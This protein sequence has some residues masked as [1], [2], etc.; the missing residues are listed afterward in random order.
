MFKSI[1]SKRPRAPL[2]QM[3]R[4]TREESKVR[5]GFSGVVWVGL[6]VVFVLLTVFILLLIDGR[7]VV[8]A[9]PARQRTWTAAM[10][11]QDWAAVRRLA[12]AE[13]DKNPRDPEAQ[14]ALGVALMETGNIE[15]A[16]AYLIT[17]GS[18]A[19]S[20]PEYTVALADLYTLRGATEQAAGKLRDA[21]ELDPSRVDLHWRLA[22]AAYALGQ[23]DESLQELQLI[24]RQ[25]PDNWDAYRLTADVAIG[26]AQS[27]PPEEAAA[28]Y[29]D[30]IGY[31]KLYTAMVPDARAL[32][33]MARVY[34]S[35]TPPDTAAARRAAE[36]ALA[37]NPTD[38]QAHLALARNDLIRLAPPNRPTP[39]EVKRGIER[40]SGHYTLA[41]SCF[42]P[43]RDASLMGRILNSRKNLAEAEV[44]YRV[45]ACVDTS[46]KDYAYELGMNL[47]TQQ[48]FEDARDS[49]E[50]VLRLDPQNL[51]A[52]DNLGMAQHRTGDPDAAEKTYL[53]AI[54]VDANDVDAYKGLGDIYVD[55]GA[56][57]Q[58][59]EMYRKALEIKPD[60][61]GA[62]GALGYL[63]YQQKDY[64]GAVDVLS[65][66]A[67][68]LFQICDP[69]P[70]LT[71]S[72]ACEQV[73]QID[74]AMEVLRKGLGC[75]ADG[76]IRQALQRLSSRAAGAQ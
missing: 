10:A 15:Q 63:L 8:S 61:P 21:L 74:R 41:A 3:E 70:I 48:K 16:E 28:R 9:A 43:A 1:D 56:S 44:A 40:A 2:P 68:S 33:K 66:A 37:L 4:L 23:Y 57:G 54:D 35:L 58:A 19:P 29:R 25:D 52:L 39:D 30:A 65:R 5:I 17:A 47:I 12:K 64:Q 20:V 13:V 73:G 18:L 31:L 27:L 42:L 38:S 75:G 60:H 32:A 55:R 50:R 62:A 14:H 46:N 49:F 6:S 67:E 76:G 22:R 34:L 26:R 11:Q 24:T 51:R 53:R 45:A 7:T 71:L 59:A 36:E 72:S 69:Q